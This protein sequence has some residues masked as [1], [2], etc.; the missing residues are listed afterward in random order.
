[1]VVPGM[2]SPLGDLLPNSPPHLQVLLKTH[3]QIP[4]PYTT[5]L[6]TSVVK[7]QLLESLANGEKTGR[8][9]PIPGHWVSSDRHMVISIKHER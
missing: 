3:Q 9:G 4:E 1:M 2:G 8:T 6:K 5:E 7:R